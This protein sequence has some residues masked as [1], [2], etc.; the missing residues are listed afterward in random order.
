MYFIIC[1]F[2]LNVG[3]RGAA[4][5]EKHKLVPKPT[6]QANPPLLPFHVER[7]WHFFIAD[8]NTLSVMDVL[9]EEV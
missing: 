6:R 7:F 9:I 2:G 8:T 4:F 1:G 3:K 5:A